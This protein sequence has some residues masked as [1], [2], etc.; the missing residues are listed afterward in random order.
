LRAAGLSP[1]EIET[2]PGSRLGSFGLMVDL[3]KQGQAIA[4]VPE[5][6]VVREFQSKE[7][8]LACSERLVSPQ[9]YYLLI[10]QLAD[11]HP[12]VTDFSE[13]VLGLRV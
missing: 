6:F 5:Y 4:I 8:V 12:K 1:G 9:S 10:P 2:L 13:W 7:L 11:K 3:A